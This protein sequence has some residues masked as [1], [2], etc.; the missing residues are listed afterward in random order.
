MQRGI[1]VPCDQDTFLQYLRAQSSDAQTRRQSLA[2]IADSNSIDF[3]AGVANE[4]FSECK[5]AEGDMDGARK[6]L[7]RARFIMQLHDDQ[8]AQY[9]ILKALVRITVECDQFEEAERWIQ[10]AMDLLEEEDGE[11]RTRLLNVLAMT[12]LLR[13]M[14]VLAA[15]RV[16]EAFASCQD[17]EIAWQK[18]KKEPVVLDTWNALPFQKWAYFKEAWESRVHRPFPYD[19][20]FQMIE[21]SASPPLQT[22]KAP[23]EESRKRKWLK[24]RFW[25]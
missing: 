22:T 8:I 20:V 13:R 12:A 4:E 6:Y 9:R 16:I 17:S 25:T 5:E 7:L 15:E 23:G 2:T 11:E 18:Q 21:E 10:R 24:W 14:P 3:Y 19:G 1:T